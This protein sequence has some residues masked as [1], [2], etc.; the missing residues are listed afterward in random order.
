MFGN[1]SSRGTVGKGPRP[2]RGRGPGRPLALEP[3]EK[4]DLPSF[5]APA[6]Y[7]T[8]HSPQGVAVGDLRGD[9]RRDVVTATGTAVSVLLGNG[10]GTFRPAVEFSTA[11]TN[12][13]AVALARLRPGGPLDI[14]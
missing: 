13:Q 1:W 8:G 14:V 4:R 5:I 2:R 7:D 3:L 10:D 11:G 12:S 9:G 6:L